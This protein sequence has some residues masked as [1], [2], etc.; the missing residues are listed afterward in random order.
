MYNKKI[1]IFFFT[2]IIFKLQYFNPHKKKLQHFNIKRTLKKW[3]KN[4]N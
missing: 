2:V 4:D 3:E 1:I